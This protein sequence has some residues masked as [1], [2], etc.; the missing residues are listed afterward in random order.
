MDEEPVD[1][2][3]RSPLRL[4]QDH[5]PRDASRAVAERAAARHHDSGEHVVRLHGPVATGRRV[6]R[7]LRQRADC[8]EGQPEPLRPR[9]QRARRQPRAELRARSQPVLE[10]HQ[11]RLRSGLRFPQLA[12]QR[13]VRHHLGPALRPAD[14]EHRGRSEDAVADGPI[15]PTTGSSRPASSTRS[16]RESP[17]TSAT[18]GGYTGTSPRPTIGPYYRAIT[19]TTAS[20]RRS[21]RGCRTAAVTRSATSTISI[22]PRSGRWT[23]T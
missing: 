4:L 13:G 7:S 14:S 10:R 5:L 12:R 15:A 20:L 16:C 21:I 17:P 23:T 6:L 8:G 18:S 19:I 9:D 11:S 3:R 2:D 1:T 22:H